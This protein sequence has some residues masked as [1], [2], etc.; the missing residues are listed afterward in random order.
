[1]N[2]TEYKKYIEDLQKLADG[3]K[4][5]DM[6]GFTWYK[7][8]DGVETDYGVKHLWWSIFIPKDLKADGK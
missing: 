8:P 6:F 2:I 1:M 4:L 3:T 7:R 5:V